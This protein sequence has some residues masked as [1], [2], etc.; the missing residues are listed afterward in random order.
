M[1]ADRLLLQEKAEFAR[2]AAPCPAFGTCGGCTVQDLAYADQLALKQQRV[3]RILGALDPSLQVEIVP[4]DDPWRYRNKAEFTFG[5]ARR[6]EHAEDRPGLVLGYHAARS[7]WRIVDLDDCLLLPES[8]MAVVR[9]VRALV[10]ESGLSPYNPR[11]HH[12]VFRYL[13]VRTSRATGKLLVSIMTTRVERPVLERMAEALIAEHADL[14]SV[15]WGVNEK[16]ADV[17]IPDELFLL[18]G[19]PHLDDRI[20]PFAVA[21]H[22]MNFLQPNPLQAERLYARLAELV[23]TM[24]TAAAWDLYCGIGLITL[25]LASKFQVVYGIDSELRNLEMAQR[26]AQANGITNAQF[27]TGKAEELLAD[28][29]FWLLEAKPEVV[30]VDPPRSG[31]HPKVIGALLAAKPKQLVYVSCNAHA[32]ARDLQP[33]LVGYPRYRIVHASAF[34][35]FPHT[36]HLEVLTLLERS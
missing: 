15:Y 16:V 8:V 7:F 36:N 28:K 6:P 11:T 32:L 17:A 25:Y 35:L 9:H 29:R 30:V 2:I 34:D 13:L 12:G 1:K 24:P 19:A 33:L 22:P 18:K 26:N 31:L 10:R 14:A 23:S 27:R 21:L 20:G 3:L 4:M 5:Y